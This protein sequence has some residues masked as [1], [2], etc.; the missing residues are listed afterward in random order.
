[1]LL[2]AGCVQPAMQ[3][4]INAATARVL[5]ALG[6][7][8]LVPAAAGCCGAIRQHL[9][10]HAGAADN[11]L[12]NIDAWW[13]HVEA[14]AE[15]IVMN[16]SGCGV[17]V[18]EY[19]YLLRNDPVYAAKARRIGELTRDLSELL[20]PLVEQIKP[21]L[22]PGSTRERVVFHPPCTLQHGQKIR[23]AV[24]GALRALGADLL[25]FNESHLCC[26]SAGTYSVLEPELAYRLRDRKLEN[27]QAPG[28]DV[29]LSAN[30]GCITHL[31]SGTGTRVEHWIEWLDRRLA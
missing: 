27:L 23:G 25:P 20:P 18:K 5:D 4:N 14:G 15:A 1:M 3:P 12:T 22:K 24:E 7:E 10:D 9:N 17:L 28:P 6:I 19:G 11:M 13:P 2:L 8:T 26:G 29:V 16:A 21:K 31:Q 30:V